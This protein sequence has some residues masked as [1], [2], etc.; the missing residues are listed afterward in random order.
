MTTPTEGTRAA[1][2]TEWPNVG[3]GIVPAAERAKG[4]FQAQVEVVAAAMKAEHERENET[5]KADLARRNA[6]E[7]ESAAAEEAAVESDRSIASAERAADLANLAAFYQGLSNLAVG[8]VE[9]ARAG[10]E[11]VQKA[12]AA[13]VTLYTGILAFVFVAGDNPLPAR[14]VLAPVFLGLAV[15]LSTG[16]LAYLDAGRDATP[17]PA[18]VAGTEPKVIERL[19]STITAASKIATRRS[20]A[21]R[22]SVISLGVGLVYIALPFMT[23]GGAPSPATPTPVATAPAWPTPNAG[24]PDALNAI[25]YKAQTDEVAKARQLAAEAA[26]AQP[27]VDDTGVL[28]ALG[29]IGLILTIGVPAIWRAV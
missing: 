2:R 3:D 27:G 8:A 10:A 6:R 29:A 24:V 1:R 16:Y 25:V 28:V 23:I 19:N 11:V 13:I 4:V 5:Y 20:Y 15:V 17:G 18:V 22:A 9:R 12:S 26:A 14:G 7:A 21:L